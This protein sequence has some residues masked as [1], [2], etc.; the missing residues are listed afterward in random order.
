MM[1]PSDILKSVAEFYGDTNGPPEKDAN[2]VRGEKLANG[3][4]GLPM[5]RGQRVI[6]ESD[7]TEALGLSDRRVAIYRQT[8]PIPTFGRKS[9]KSDV[10]LWKETPAF[11]VACGILA[12]RTPVANERNTLSEEDRE[13]IYQESLVDRRW[14]VIPIT[15]KTERIR[16]SGGSQ[17]M[18][19]LASYVRQVFAAQ[20]HRRFVPSL[21]FTEFTVEIL[22]WDRA[23]VIFSEALDSHTKAAHF[24]HIIATIVS[25]T[26]DELGFDA[27]KPMTRF[28]Y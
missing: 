9:L 11:P 19:Q 27:I 20:A 28:V 25:C 22:L 2:G 21:L 26:N 18:F 4:T 10:F 16:K 13:A 6:Q 5:H 12:P 23:G 7:I 17:A 1:L 15:M 3:W 14:C 24:C 8:N